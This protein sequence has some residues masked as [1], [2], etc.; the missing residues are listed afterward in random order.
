MRWT[1]DYVSW[2]Y[3]GNHVRTVS[4][5]ASVDAIATHREQHL[6]MNF[7]LPAWDKW[8]NGFDPAGMPW[9]AQYDYVEVYDFD[10][11]DQSDDPFTFRWRDDFD[12]FDTSK[13]VKS[14]NW[15]FNDNLVLF[16]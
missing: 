15:S 12:T 9:F 11:N 7:W 14:D 13:W 5:G 1:P 3:D 4:G 10:P 6:M 2:Y 8:R 16:E